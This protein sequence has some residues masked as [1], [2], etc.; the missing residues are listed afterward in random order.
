MKRMSTARK[1]AAETTSKEEEDDEE[2]EYSGN[3]GSGEDE[4][5]EVFGEENW[6]QCGNC[7]YDHDCV[8]LYDCGRQSCE[9]QYF[10]QLV[11]FN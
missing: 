8:N 10:S 4:K 5:Y 6:R 1:K 9:N 7:C 3:E 11:I 2:D